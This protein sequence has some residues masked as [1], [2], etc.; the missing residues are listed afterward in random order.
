MHLQ[1]ALQQ[2][3]TVPVR[4]PAQLASREALQTASRTVPGT[5]PMAT[6]RATTYATNLASNGRI[7]SYLGRRASAWPY[8]EAPIGPSAV[9]RAVSTPKLPASTCPCCY[10]ALTAAR[11]PS[12]MAIVSAIS[13]L[14]SQSAMRG[15]PVQ[16]PST[17]KKPALSPVL[18]CRARVRKLAMAFSP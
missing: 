3:L 11:Y 1:I 7:V 12:T 8:G 9:S 6:P 14:L 4:I 15:F 10:S 2:A 18:A 13:A 16:S 5:V 17:F